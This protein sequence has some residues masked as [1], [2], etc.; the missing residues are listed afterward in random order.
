M[1]NDAIEAM[2]A[3]RLRRPLA[4]GHDAGEAAGKIGGEIQKIVIELKILHKSLEKTLSEGLKQTAEYM[5]DVE[6]AKGIWWSLTGGRTVHGRKKFSIERRNSP[7]RR[8]RYGGCEAGRG[9]LLN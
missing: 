7:G 2:F 3:K 6:R 9:F 1:P 4:Q 8:S 5:I